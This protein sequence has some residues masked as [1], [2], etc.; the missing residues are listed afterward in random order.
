MDPI[1]R[2]TL[3]RGAGAALAL[4]YLERM[5][6]LSALAVSA[7]A[8]PLRLAYA[9]VPNG[10]SMP[11]WRPAQS[12]LIKSLPELLAPLEP[13]RGSIT[14]LSG[15]SQHHAEANGDGPGDHARSAAAWLTGVQP[16]KTAGSD[17]HG[18]ISVDQIAAAKVGGKTK[19]AS[20]E[21]GCE[22]GAVAGDCDSGYACAY[23]SSI[24]WRSP[25][26][27]NAKETSPRLVFERLFGEENASVE[28]ARKSNYFRASILDVVMQ[29]TA[30]L[31][32][33]LGKKDKEKLDEYLTGIREVEV[34]L[35]KFEDQAGVPGGA[36]RPGAVPVDYGE[37][38]RLMGDMMVLAFQAD[39][40]RICTFMF[41]NEGSNR[42]YPM[43]GVPDGHHDMS[44]HG[45]DD[46]KLRNK[47]AI[48]RFH[49]DQLA[50]VVQ[51]LASVKEGDRS[52]LD[53]TM[54]V[55]G[56]GISDGDRHNHDDLPIMIIGKGAGAL[57]G[58]EH[59][60]FANGTPLNN[61]HVSLLDRMGCPGELYGDATGPLP[62]LF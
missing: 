46:Y 24:S 28:Q 12:G 61:L 8:R 27:P 44:H 32:R 56:A 29:D 22:R 38:I 33:K 51:R 23:S 20:L 35:K 58:G 16:R 39:L 42:S 62:G 10:I 6:P 36:V 2:R 3:L 55:Y 14:M 43:I 49:M 40:T 25:N 21:I 34:R 13:F 52:L 15:L 26:T 9:F 11:L 7:P 1:S 5:M 57:K 4:P 45:N 17:I 48:D 18:G 19:F 54:F 53:N 59:R 41:A 30:D 47:A 60:V 37:H 50:Y 31:Q